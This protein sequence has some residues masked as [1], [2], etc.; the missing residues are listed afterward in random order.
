MALDDIKTVTKTR[1]QLI[2]V[3]DAMNIGNF[4]DNEKT[5]KSF[6]VVLDN[7]DGDV[8]AKYVVGDALEAINVHLT[9]LTGERPKPV[10]YKGFSPKVFRD[11]IKASPL[12]IEL[13]RC[14]VATSSAQF[15][16]DVE[17]LDFDLDGVSKPQRFSMNEAVTSGQYNPKIQSY[18]GDISLGARRGIVFNVNKG[19]KL[20]VTFYIKAVLNRF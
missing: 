10:V 2:G 1:T 13:M 5:P 3:R 7:T 20:T 4:V 17:I 18:R 16:N 15:E 11:Y 8:D 14:E 19:E 6:K 9:A 12:M